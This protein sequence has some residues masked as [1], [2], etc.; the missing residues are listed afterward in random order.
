M[1]KT[2]LPEDILIYFLA[3]KSD[4]FAMRRALKPLRMSRSTLQ[5]ERKFYTDWDIHHRSQNLA[6][7]D[8]RTP[9]CMA[10]GL[11]RCLELLLADRRVD[12]NLADEDGRT[13]LCMA[14][15]VGEDR[16]VEHQTERNGGQS[17]R[18]RA[19]PRAGEARQ[20]EDSG[21]Q[22][23]SV[24]ALPASGPCGQGRRQ[25]PKGYSGNEVL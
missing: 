19:L 16:Y 5:N 4:V 25:G 18:A 10:A 15:F 9:L 11:G 14:A 22:S 2:G 1:F 7:E 3:P 20:T 12:P 8:G 13:P 23:R 6:G 21:G 24:R 17:R